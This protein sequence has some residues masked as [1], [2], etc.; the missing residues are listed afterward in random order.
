M[1]V[2]N[3]IFI[4]AA[5]FASVLTGSRTGLF[6]SIIAI[7][8]I[9]IS[10]RKTKPV[11]NLLIFSFL[12]AAGILLLSYI[13]AATLARLSTTGSAISSMDFGRR[14]ILWD[15]AFQVFLEHPLTGSGAGTM[16]AIIGAVAHNTYLSILGEG[17]IIGFVLFMILLSIVFREAVRHTHSEMIFWLTILLIW[18]TGVLMLTWE[19]RKATWLILT[20]IVISGQS[21]SEAAEEE[22]EISSVDENQKMGISRKAYSVAQREK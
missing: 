8:Y 2:I 12:A 11:V 19:Y 18:C 15:A 5:L 20:L 3:L 1:R 16:S 7:I 17:G 4:P 21:R 10:L 6:T 22:A 13:P 14:G 9:L